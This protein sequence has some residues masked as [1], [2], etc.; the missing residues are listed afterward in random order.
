M[1]QAIGETI[2][3]I[4]YLGF[5][6]LAGLTMLARGMTPLVK[7]AGLMA[8]LLGAG[9]AFHLLPRSYALW[10]AGLEANAP[11]LGFGKF[12]TSITMTVF[13]VILYYIWRERYQIKG[14]PGLTEAMWALAALR[15]GLCLLPQNQWLVYRQPLAFGI[16]RNIP[17]AIIGVLIIVLF[18]RETRRTGDQAFRF[19]P[20]A[21]ALSF[22]FY[23]PVVLFSGVAPAVGMLMIPKTMAYVWIVWMCWKLYVQERSC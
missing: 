19:M 10:T 12:V 5:A 3:D 18:A 13:Y 21:V 4:L 23:L 9:D 8:T 14:R 20:L 1:A 16:F 17:F 6:L 11:A 15:I 7:K 22:G 2:F